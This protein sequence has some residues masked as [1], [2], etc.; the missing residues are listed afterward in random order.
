MSHECIGADNEE[1]DEEQEEASCYL[2]VWCGIRFRGEPVEVRA[3]SANLTSRW[4]YLGRMLCA[5]GLENPTA[6]PHHNGGHSD[7]VSVK[8][9][10]ESG[11]DSKG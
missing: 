2:I 6:P 1:D 9:E 3:N 5:L 7:I 8:E 10:C 4:D 11:V